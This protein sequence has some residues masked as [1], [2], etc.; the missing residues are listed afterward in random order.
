M[1]EDLVNTFGSTPRR[2]FLARLAGAAAG[3]SAGAA[4]P[5]PLAAAPAQASPNDRWLA[6]LTGRHRCLFD[7][8]QHGDGL[9]LIHMLNYITTYKSAYGE[10]PETVNA[11][12][13]FYGAPGLPATMPLAWND[14]MW[15][16]YKIGE[17]LKLIDPDTKAPSKRNMFYRPRAG[18]PVFFRGAVTAAGI[19]NLQ[20]MGAM[21]LMCNNAFSAWVGFLSGSGAK[22]N[23][24][25]IDRDIRANL[26][27]G[28]ITV[29]AL[30]IAIEK[31]QGKGIA[32]NRQ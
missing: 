7:A 11:I 16:K 5:S 31:A 26:L 13:T 2:G 23:A 10:G 9:P 28:V 1:K 8:P 3:L 21:F 12:G 15:A 19:E 32:Y 18:D 27:P 22:G 17:L 29:P 20:K 30:V 14:A 24:A 6:G 25:E 4:V